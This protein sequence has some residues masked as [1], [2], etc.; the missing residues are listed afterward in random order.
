MLVLLIPTIYVTHSLL[1]LQ[2]EV[3]L[4]RG[5]NV[6]CLDEWG[7]SAVGHMFTNYRWPTEKIQNIIFLL[8]WHSGLLVKGRTTSFH[9]DLDYED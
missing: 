3:L 8:K 5:A 4:R 2:Y 7:Q 6:K 9:L 1:A